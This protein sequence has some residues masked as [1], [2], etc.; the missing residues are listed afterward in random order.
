MLNVEG[1]ILIPILIL[2]DKAVL[3]QFFDKSH[4]ITIFEIDEEGHKENIGYLKV[5]Y[6]NS[7][8]PSESDSDPTIITNGLDAIYISNFYI[9]E[10]Y[11]DN[12]IATKVLSV[13][14][15][16]AK[17]DGYK[18]ITGRLHK[19]EFFDKLKYLYLEKF[20]ANERMDLET[21]LIFEWKF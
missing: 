15:D 8:R 18:L 17:L 9:D 6:S 3:C 16:K 2:N 20:K 21:Y 19:N 5:T 4:S 12:G 11:R 7:S 14:L 13:F 10:K 1:E